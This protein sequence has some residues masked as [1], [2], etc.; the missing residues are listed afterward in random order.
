MLEY[1]A[2][3]AMIRA[4]TDWFQYGEKSSAYFLKLEKYKYMKKLDLEC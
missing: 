2:R 3:G 1:K 4:K